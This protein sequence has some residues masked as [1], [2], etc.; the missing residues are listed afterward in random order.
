MDWAGLGSGS[1]TVTS[2]FPKKKKN[3]SHDDLPSP[4]WDF[5]VSWVGRTDLKLFK[6]P[7]K[8]LVRLSARPPV[9]LPALWQ[10]SHTSPSFVDTSIR[11]VA[12]TF[13]ITK[14]QLLT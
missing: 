1:Q 12:R 14:T 9:L 6:I 11:A 4:L 3:L 8:T 10:P 5:C 7:Q 13:K 2:F